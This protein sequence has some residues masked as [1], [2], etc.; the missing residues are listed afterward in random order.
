M[1]HSGFLAFCR[2]FWLFLA[3]FGFFGLSTAKKVIC[4][5]PDDYVTPIAGVFISDGALSLVLYVP[6]SF[7]YNKRSYIYQCLT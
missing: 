6:T 4:E 7:A 3:H 1:W 2:S 5:F